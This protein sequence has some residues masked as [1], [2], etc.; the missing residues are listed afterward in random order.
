M[1]MLDS[2]SVGSTAFAGTLDRT[3]ETL[4]RTSPARSN[5]HESDCHH[6]FHTASSYVCIS[7]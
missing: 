5:K 3:N 7:K 4:D 6:D 2:Q 1:E